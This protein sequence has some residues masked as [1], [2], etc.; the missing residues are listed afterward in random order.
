MSGFEHQACVYGSD[1]D[2][3]AMAV[4]FVK[5]GLDA[6]ERVMVTT[7]PHNLELIGEALGALAMEIDIAE[8]AYFGRRPAERVAEFDR[9]LRWAG[10]G[11]AT[12]RTRI[13][14]EPVWTGKSGQEIRAWQR[15]E[16]GLNEM[17]AGTS[18]W[19]ICPYDART[20]A[21][22]VLASAH[23]THPSMITGAAIARSP[24]FADPAEFARECDSVALPPPPAA[25]AEHR[26]TTDLA[27][28]RRF[29]AGRARR[30]GLGGQ[31][32]ELLVA[33]VHEVAAHVRRAGDGGSVRI[34]QRHGAILCEVRQP[35]GR[36]S[37]PF[38]GFRPP[39]LEP[40]PS[41]GLWVSRR[42]CDSVEV[43]SD[44]A[45]CTYRLQVPGLRTWG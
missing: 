28:V 12:V 24:G 8:T 31:P 25:T 44:D 30:L 22:D 32:V 2:F 6:G 1:E 43:R 37:D 23:R 14:A 35:G 26:F 17:L 21:P 9:Y 34:W 40:S 11:P 15:L 42:L 4:P 27:G 7:T 10:G 41:D 19:M 5:G 33:A 16:S 20:A 36:I 3:L 13:L 39:A 38:C 18:L 45:G 29:V